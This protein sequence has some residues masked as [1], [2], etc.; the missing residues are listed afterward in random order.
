MAED[1]FVNPKEPQE[2]LWQI[3]VVDSQNGTVVSSGVALGK[4][5][6]EAMAKL[7]VQDSLTKSSTIKVYA[8]EI[9][10]PVPTQVVAN[11]IA[12]KV[13]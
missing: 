3:Y 13:K 2:A 8:R 7:K 5:A 4:S 1:L 11:F 12:E 6:A 9:G 10:Y